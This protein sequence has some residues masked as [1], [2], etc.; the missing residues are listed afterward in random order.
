MPY[1][2]SKMF[3]LLVLLSFNVTAARAGKKLKVLF[4]GNSY[5]SVNNMPQIVADIASSMGDTLDWEMEAP[6]GY[7]FIAHYAFHPP[8]M[9]KIQAGKWDYVVLQEQSLNP[10]IPTPHVETSVLPYARKLDSIVSVYNNCAETIFYMTWGRKNGDAYNC[11]FYTTSYSW[12]HFCTYEAMDSVIRMRYTMMADSNQ[13]IV[14]PAGAVWHFIRTYYP[15]IEL[16]DADESH[17]SPAGSYAVACTFYTTLFKKNPEL[18][19]YSY[20][21][22]GAENIRQ[23]TKRVVFDSMLYWHIGQYRTE[24]LFNFGLAS[25]TANFTNY[26]LNATKYLWHFGDGQTD[27]VANPVH[28]YTVPGNYTIMLVAANVATGCR[29]T[30]YAQASITATDVR[31]VVTLG[32]T[33]TV[34]PNPGTGVFTINT[35][36]NAYSI[37]I[38]NMLG[39]IVYDSK[40]SSNTQ[41]KMQNPQ[42]GVYNLRLT[43]ENSVWSTIIFIR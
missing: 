25:G 14:S 28:Y 21:L 5:T 10:A 26:S 2:Y 39:E 19:S 37:T 13:A 38:M 8:T 32:N 42:A 35:G 7:D 41:V 27:T 1:N 6:G 34:L 15:D 33:Y 3:I 9:S 23:A 36:H 4:I 11:T 31:H 30:T 16:Y 43:N 12:P 40:G 22:A 18:I 29:D 20:G 17:P 24:A